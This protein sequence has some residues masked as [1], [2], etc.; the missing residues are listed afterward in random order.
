[1]ASRLRDLLKALKVPCVAFADD[2]TLIATCKNDLQLLL[3]MAYR[4]SVR[5]RF[6]FN[7]Q[8]CSM[9]IIGNKKNV[10]DNVYLGKSKISACDSDVHLGL[11]LSNSK[12]GEMQFVHN[13]IRT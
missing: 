9:L 12:D 3:D 7:P 10:K 2:V 1:M 4:Y 5:W 13:K 11:C 8:K 6:E